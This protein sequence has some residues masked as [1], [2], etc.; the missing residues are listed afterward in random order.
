MSDS[1]SN[2]I[3]ELIDPLGRC[4]SPEV[5]R[6]IADLRADKQLQ[7]RIQLLGQ[8]CNEGELTAEETAEYETIVRFTKFISTLQSKARTLLRSCDS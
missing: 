8:K 1:R 6:K 5:A 4:L 3:D 7:D 2:L